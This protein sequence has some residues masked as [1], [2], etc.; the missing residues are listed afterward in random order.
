[1]HLGV[2]LMGK[3]CKWTIW[4]DSDEFWFG[5]YVG[6]IGVYI[7][8]NSV[9]GKLR[10]L[11]SRIL[12]IPIN[13]YWILV[14]DM[15]T[16]ML[17]YILK[18]GVILYL[19]HGNFYKEKCYVGVRNGG[20]RITL[21]GLPLSGIVCSDLAHFRKVFFNFL[22][23]F[24]MLLDLWFSFCNTPAYGRNNFILSSKSVGFFYCYTY[25]IWLQFCF[26]LLFGWYYWSFTLF[27]HN[28]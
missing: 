8:R 15:Y 3:E 21:S 10:F 26:A 18:W 16:E 5:R 22:L 9:N 6:S 7:S 14:N 1:M 20:I 12:K 28:F 23:P 4:N 13:K 11:H 19:S 27:F 24:S 2:E 25:V 17:T